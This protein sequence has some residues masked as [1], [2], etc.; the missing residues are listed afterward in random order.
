MYLVID[1]MFE[2]KI[3]RE[4][5]KDALDSLLK[6]GWL[7]V[8]VHPGNILCNKNYEICLIDLGWAVHKSDE[9]Y[10][11][12]PTGRRLFAELRAIQENNLKRL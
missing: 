9:P 3:N 1:Q 2:C 10:S 5:I 4:K 12:H 6:L 7:H 8:D 11:G